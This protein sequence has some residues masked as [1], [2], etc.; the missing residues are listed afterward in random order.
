[1]IKNKLEHVLAADVDVVAVDRYAA[2]PFDS[3]LPYCRSFAFV[4]SQGSLRLST[5][6]EGCVAREQARGPESRWPASQPWR[7]LCGAARWRLRCAPRSLLGVFV[8]DVDFW[9]CSA[10]T[11]SAV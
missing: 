2:V 4:V 5:F 7:E 8:G 9:I 11:R 3:A 6:T 1:M 10:P